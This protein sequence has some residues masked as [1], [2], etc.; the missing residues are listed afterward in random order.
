MSS[1]PPG[2]RVAQAVGLTGSAWLAGMCRPPHQTNKSNSTDRKHRLPQHQRHPGAPEIPPRR[3][4]PPRHHP[5]RLP[6]RL[7]EW[8][9]AE[10]AR[11]GAGGR[12]VRVPRLRGAPRRVCVGADDAR[13]CGFVCELGGADAGDCAVDGCGDGGGESGAVEQGGGRG[14]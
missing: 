4:R 8:Q 6:Q 12:C 14:G 11:R 5:A 3:R 9:G 7:R 10:P 13:E 1:Y 2:V